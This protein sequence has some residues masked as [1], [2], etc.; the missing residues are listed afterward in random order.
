ME[1]KLLKRESY[2]KEYKE[3]KSEMVSSPNLSSKV[4]MC[5]AEFMNART[6]FHLLHLK[7]KG[8]ASYAQHMAL[9]EFYESLPDLVD[10]IAE[11]YQGITESLLEY[12]QTECRKLETID[13]ALEYLR[14]LYTRISV[15]QEVMP[16]S[17]IVN[18]IDLIKDAI[19]KVKYK[20]IF[21]K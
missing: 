5:I 16:Y 17:E 18:N 21:L 14:E 8:S 19:N 3:E 2:S 6:S 13:D 12:P 20:L 4:G 9:G 1:K 15:M 7:V 11:G 10:T